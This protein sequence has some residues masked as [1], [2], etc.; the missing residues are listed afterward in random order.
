MRCCTSCP[1][2]RGRGLVARR[3]EVVV[4]GSFSACRRELLGLS[5]ALF[6]ARN[7]RE[8]ALLEFLA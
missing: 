3:A 4:G 5:A 8:V 7:R 2:R 6:P 1:A